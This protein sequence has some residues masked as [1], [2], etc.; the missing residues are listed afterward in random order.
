LSQNYPNPFNP[1]TTIR[2]SIQADSRLRL[3]SSGNDKLELKVFDVLGREVA[4][5]VNEHLQPGTYEVEF[6]PEK[7]GQAGLSSGV[8]YYKLTAGDYSETK[9][10]VL[11]K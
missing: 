8:Y 4:V 1:T 5:L 3:K 11:I 10:M 6:D 7:S 2:F 9:K